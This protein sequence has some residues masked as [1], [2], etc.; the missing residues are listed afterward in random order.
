MFRRWLSGFWRKNK[1]KAFLLAR[2]AMVLIIVAAIGFV[3][4][5]AFPR[6]TKEENKS[7]Y[8]PQK[9]SIMGENI[10]EETYN[11]NSNT[12]DDFISYC[13]LKDAKNAYNF[14]TEDCKEVLYPTVQDFEKYYLNTIF[15]EYRTYNLQS[16]VTKEKYVT[17]RMRVMDDLL[18]TGDYNNS[19]KYQDYITINNSEE[20]PKISINNFIKKEDL[21]ITTQTDDFEIKVFDRKVYFDYEE[22]KISIK[23][24]TGNNILLDSFETTKGIKLIGNNGVNC[25]IE[26]LNEEYKLKQHLNPGVSR[27]LNIK[28]KKPYASEIKSKYIEFSDIIKNEFAYKKEKNR[29]DYK[30]RLSIKINL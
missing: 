8:Q 28:F 25:Y 6:E 24:L 27:T 15:K 16:W 19:V 10:S 3:I 9:T 18:S 7:F 22:Y 1:E 26:D 17:Y 29:K 23:N 5:S 30:D 2:G 14:L 11:K 20:N 12:V 21:N 4:A 13:N